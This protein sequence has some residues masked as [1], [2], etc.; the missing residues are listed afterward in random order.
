MNN[1]EQFNKECNDLQRELSLEDYFNEVNDNI[2]KDLS[3]QLSELFEFSRKKGFSIH[4]DNLIK[5]ELINSDDINQI[6]SYLRS[7][8]LI[9]NINY[10][11]ENNDQKLNIMLTRDAIKKCLMR[12]EHADK[13]C[14]YYLLLDKI[15]FYYN[16]YILKMK[17]YEIERNRVKITSLQTRLDKIKEIGNGMCRIM[18]EKQH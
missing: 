14:D 4:H 9:E 11:V 13:Y 1:L 7:Q 17:D 5:Y 10:I 3:I 6:K 15:F 16:E 12:A 8:N 2:S 18:N